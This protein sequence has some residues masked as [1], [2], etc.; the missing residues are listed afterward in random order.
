MEDK[1]REEVYN[2]DWKRIFADR[3]RIDRETR[4]GLESVLSSQR[5]RIEKIQQ[6]LL[7]AEDA[8]DALLSEISTADD[9]ED[10]LARR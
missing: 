8:K 6:I 5:G 2:V 1:F 3:L 10:V 9:A 4:C 7:Y